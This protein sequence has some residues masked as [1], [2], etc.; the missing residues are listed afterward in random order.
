MRKIG[1]AAA[2]AVVT[3]AGY[4]A[5]PARADGAA[6]NNPPVAVITNAL[7][8]RPIPNVG[9][10]YTFTAATSYD[11]DG[12][13]VSYYWTT[14]CSYNGIGTGVEYEMIVHFGDSCLIDL[15]VTDNNAAVGNQQITRSH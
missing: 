10:R 2:L 1:F 9:V 11:T 6:L 13:I 7:S 14:N 8:P 3:A 5:V 4:A 12:S 15:Y